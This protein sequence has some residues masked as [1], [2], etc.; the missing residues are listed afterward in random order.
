M[1]FLHIC[2]Y[3]LICS[4]HIGLLI[5]D[6][7]DQISKIVSAITLYIVH[8]YRQIFKGNNDRHTVVTNDLKYPPVARC[9]RIHPVAYHG[10]PCLRFE[11]IGLKGK[12][13]RFLV[14]VQK[15]KISAKSYTIL[16]HKWYFILVLFC[17]L[18]CPFG[19][20]P[21]QGSCYQ[22]VK[23]KFSWA[24]AAGYCVREGGKLVTIGT[25]L[26]NDWLKQYL[27]TRGIFEHSLEHLPKILN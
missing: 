8:I 11:I 14:I 15:Q 13:S 7:H 23:E 18:A 6:F 12:Y 22:L 26:E 24:D 9:V 21:W 3:S 17:I 20:C 5:A 2:Y 4:G 25:S 27:L 1:H 19:Y 10:Y 16:G